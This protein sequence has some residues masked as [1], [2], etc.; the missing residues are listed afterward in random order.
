M[1]ISQTNLTNTISKATAIK[2]ETVGSKEGRAKARWELRGWR[3]HILLKE[4]G[5]LLK[6]TLHFNMALKEG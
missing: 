3:G 6:E 1:E 2:S 5:K 4:F